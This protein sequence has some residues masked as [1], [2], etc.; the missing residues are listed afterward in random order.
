MQDLYTELKNEGN[1]I[2]VVVVNGS[3]AS[4]SASKLVN[5]CDFPVFQD[6][7]SVNAWGLHAG[8]KDDII[9][10]NSD[11]TLSSFLEFRGGTN[12]NLGSSSGYNNVK[13]KI[14][15]AY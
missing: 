9:I 11:G 5:V 7:Y 13:T 1:E 3:S 6:T 14:L 8:G 2:Q 12:I 4:S 10:Y 15:E